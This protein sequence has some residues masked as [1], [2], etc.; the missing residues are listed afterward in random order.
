MKAYC[1]RRLHKAFVGQ[2]KGYDKKVKK[3]GL[4]LKIST[5][6]VFLALRVKFVCEVS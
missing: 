2:I 4:T 5:E 6:M 1:A 3:Q